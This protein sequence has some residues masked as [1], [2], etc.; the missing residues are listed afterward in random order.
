ME[1]VTRAA[2]TN[3]IVP[4]VWDNGSFNTVP[5]YKN[6]YFGLFNR[7]ENMETNEV[8]KAMIEGIMNGCDTEYPF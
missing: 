4:F 1:Y 8:S 7:K 2:R 6:E 5:D 3:G